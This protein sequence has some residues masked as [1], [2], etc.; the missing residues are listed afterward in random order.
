MKKFLTGLLAA[1]IV[2]GMSACTIQLSTTNTI[3]GRNSADGSDEP[4]PYDELTLEEK[5]AYKTV[6]ELTA[7]T[8]YSAD[9]LAPAM[10]ASTELWGYINLQGEWKVP[11]KYKNA[12][13]FSGDY[14]RAND[15]YSDYIYINRDGEEVLSTV[16]KQPL[17][18]ATVFSDGIAAVT[19]PTSYDQKTQYVN[20]EGKAAIT[21][22][23]LPATKGVNYKTLKY[24]EVAT[25]F[26]DGKAVIMRTTNATLAEKNEN[27]YPEVAYVIDTTG[28]A[29]ASLPAGMDAS[30]A[31]FDDNMMIVVRNEEGLY[32]LASDTGAL[33]SP[34]IYK[35][36][37]HCE[38]G[39]YLIQDAEG[40]YGYMNK[41]G[42][43]VV[44]CIY[45]KA[46]P[47]SEGLGA[48]YDGKGWGFIN[49]LGEVIIPCEFDDVKALKTGYSGEESDTGAFS[50]G[51]A[52]VSKG[53]YWGIIDLNGEI[54]I[55]AETDEC[56]VMAV[57]G[58]YISFKLNGAYGVLTTECKYV[59]A[60]GFGAIGE[61]R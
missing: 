10:D 3:P 14:A 54:L 1:A 24:L 55:A 2:F 23:K 58:G 13:S 40:M 26:R 43:R 48:V 35:S 5:M 38:G 19:I 27:R 60:P 17:N 7:A 12:L 8:D 21:I 39:M 4:T 25:P 46:L 15:L 37:A 56:P 18:G 61:F 57:C 28:L 6:V 45:E 31:G 53:R 52:V 42:R 49:D 47:F 41:N 34:C 9:L 33:V 11:A 36:I 16:E 29:L 30:P 20:P 51:I 50:S 59:L 22:K 44:G 32:G